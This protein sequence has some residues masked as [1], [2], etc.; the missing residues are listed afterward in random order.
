[1]QNLYLRLSVCLIALCASACGVLF[2]SSA[3]ACTSETVT[4]VRIT[5]PQ[6]AENVNERCSTGFNPT[7]SITF[8]IT[9]DQLSA[10][11]GSVS[12]TNW[13]Q[14]ALDPQG[15]E[16]EA[17]SMSSY[18]Y[19]NFGDGAI[20]Q[21]MLIDTSNPDRYTVYYSGSFVD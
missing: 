7:Q 2:D 15:F 3:S 13:Q 4:I 11:Q 12:I 5:P 9:P 19:G 18:L 8:T 10:A 16:E 17:A 21:A 6:G 1:M 20:Y 14:N